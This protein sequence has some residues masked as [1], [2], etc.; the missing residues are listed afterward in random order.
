M[1]GNQS[2]SINFNNNRK[3]PKIT[4]A[5]FYTNASSIKHKIALQAF[6]GSRFKRPMLENETEKWLKVQDPNHGLEITK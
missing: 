5:R 1:A 4:T 3:Q 2:E 6:F